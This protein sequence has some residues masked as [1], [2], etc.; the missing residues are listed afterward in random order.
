MSNSRMRTL[1]ED[2]LPRGDGILWNTGSNTKL[3]SLTWV[4]LKYRGTSKI[5]CRWS[6]AYIK[7]QVVTVGRSAPPGL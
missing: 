7:V 6:R 5:E 3:K 4:R 2:R 1:R